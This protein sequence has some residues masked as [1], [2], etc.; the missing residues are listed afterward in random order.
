[1]AATLKFEDVL[2]FISNSKL[3]FSI[4]K[5]P[6]SAQIS[7]K[8]S[9]AKYF[10]ED[11]DLTNAT[12]EL[13]N[14]KLPVIVSKSQPVQL[15]ENH[16]FEESSDNLKAI[17]DKN[18]KE[19]EELRNQKNSLEAKLK[20]TKKESKKNRQKAD[21]LQIML[22]KLNDDQEQEEESILEGCQDSQA[23]NIRIQNKFSLL[24][25]FKCEE[26]MSEPTL[27]IT[28]EQEVQTEEIFN[29]YDCFYCDKTLNTK[30]IL[31]SHVEVCHGRPWDRFGCNQC[32]LNF[33]NTSD[34]K[35]HVVKI[36]DP[37]KLLNCLQEL[38]KPKMK[39]FKCK[40]C[41]NRFELQSELE[42]HVLTSHGTWKERFGS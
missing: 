21:K 8:N 42:L 31:S 23:A 41:G 2:N 24:S 29:P 37:T 6:F 17:I 26:L 16:G 34:L 38:F 32:S 7:L 22:E 11:E 28:K 39:N 10:K 4:Y 12:G 30:E 15:D 13:K 9:F 27:P 36:H 40:D 14:D 5:T 18:M 25:E 1:M 3:N 19:I 20:E 33:S 35:K